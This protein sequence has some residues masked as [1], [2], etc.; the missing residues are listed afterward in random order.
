LQEC[1]FIR[2]INPEI[3]L[4]VLKLY[5]K[6]LHNDMDRSDWLRPLY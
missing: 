5:H 1:I 3:F 4:G 6:H 2:I